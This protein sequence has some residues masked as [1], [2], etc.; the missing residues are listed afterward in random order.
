MI[1]VFR[2]VSNAQRPSAVSILI[3][4]CLALDALFAVALI[5]GALR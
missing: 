2:A 5:A 4:G 1:S 3:A